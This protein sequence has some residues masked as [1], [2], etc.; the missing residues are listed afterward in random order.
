MY[1][2]IEYTKQALLGTVKLSHAFRKKEDK[3][4]LII[5]FSFLFS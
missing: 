2:L 4:M 3:I 5:D 1:Y